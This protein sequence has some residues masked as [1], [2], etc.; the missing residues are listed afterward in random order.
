MQ[1]QNLGPDDD[2]AVKINHISV[3]HTNAPARYFMANRFR[4]VGAVNTI[5]R[6]AEI[7]CPGTQRIAFATSH[8]ARKVWLPRNHLLRRRPIR[9]FGFPRDELSPSPG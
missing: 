7:N 4:R 1:H 3:E 5:D 2:P 8:P 9:P 6:A